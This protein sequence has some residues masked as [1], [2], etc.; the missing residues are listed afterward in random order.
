VDDVLY[1]QA[2]I[3]AQFQEFI[4]AEH[5]ERSS[6]RNDRLRDLRDAR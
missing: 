2:A 6:E 1:A 3:D 4:G 5:Y